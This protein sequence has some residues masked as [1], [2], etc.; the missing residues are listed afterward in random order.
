MSADANDHFIEL[1]FFYESEFFFIVNGFSCHVE[2]Q[3]S[4]DYEF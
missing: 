4:D 2:Q 1:R 3:Q